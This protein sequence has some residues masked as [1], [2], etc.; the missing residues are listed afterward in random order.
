MTGGRFYLYSIFIAVSKLHTFRT[1]ICFMDI[2]T[3]R[4]EC[5]LT[6]WSESDGCCQ[7][8]DTVII[9]KRRSVFCSKK[10]GAWWE[11]NH[12]WRKARI[13][14]RRRDKYCCVKCGVHRDVEGID[15]DHVSPVNGLNYNTPSC[16]H[17]QD[18]LQT[19]CKKH[20]KEKTAFEAGVRALKRRE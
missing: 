20:H 12:V 19:L 16:L 15:V 17:H 3:L 18:N 1:D 10:C 8:C 5:V 13:A 7:V 4:T 2:V 6:V 11:R 9:D 14:A